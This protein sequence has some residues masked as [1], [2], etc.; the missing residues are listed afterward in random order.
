MNILYRQLSELTI[1]ENCLEKRLVFYQE[2][3]YDNI[4]F[5]SDCGKYLGFK[6]Y[7]TE[8]QGKTI[9]IKPLQFGLPSESVYYYFMNNP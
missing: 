7:Q 4:Y 1:N 9:N 6:S 2:H 3:Y 5:I 8:I